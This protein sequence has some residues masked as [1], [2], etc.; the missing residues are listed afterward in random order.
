TVEDVTTP[1]VS[2]D[3]SRQKTTVTLDENNR[4][5]PEEVCEDRPVKHPGCES[6]NKSAKPTPEEP[7]FILS[8]T[9]IP[10]TLDEGAG[11]RTEPLPSA[12]ASETHSHGQ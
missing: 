7:V 12:A 10:P 3:K 1:V 6:K 9:E 2:E 11:L 4:T 5:V 8:L